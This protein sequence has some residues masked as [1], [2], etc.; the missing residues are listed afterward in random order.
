MLHFYPPIWIFFH[1]AHFGF[2]LLHLFFFFFSLLS[3][4]HIFSSFSLRP[5]WIISWRDA[6]FTPFFFSIFVFLFLRP[7]SSSN[8]TPRGPA[9]QQRG[10]APTT[11]T[12]PTVCDVGDQILES[13]AEKFSI[14]NS[15]LNSI[16][17]CILNLILFWILNWT[18]LWILDSGFGKLHKLLFDYCLMIPNKLTK[19]KNWIFFSE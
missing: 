16:S 6:H 17:F 4:L 13:T 11:L 1:Y 15:I 9:L 5:F 12:R 2:L 19:I 18:L 14:L 3:L 10:W 8:Q 7:P